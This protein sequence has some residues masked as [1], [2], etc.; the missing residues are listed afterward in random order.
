VRE[1][2]GGSTKV[3]V[4]LSLDAVLRNCL[5]VSFATTAIRPHVESLSCCQSGAAI[6]HISLRDLSPQAILGCDNVVDDID[7]VTRAQTSIHLVE[8]L[9]DSRDFIRCTLAEILEGTA[10]PRA[11][12]T[13]TTVF[14]PFG[15]GVLDV[16]VGQYVLD[17]ARRER[18]GTAI[19]SFL[20]S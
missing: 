2:S 5:L 17:L 13:T 18:R 4:A 1:A 14:S 16:A 20:P 9:T 8:Q 6:L 7:H 11:D 19:H 15:L 3:E 12:E 10:P